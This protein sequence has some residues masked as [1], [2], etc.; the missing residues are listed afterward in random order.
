MKSTKPNFFIIGAP[1]CGT[2]SWAR[3][4]SDHQQVYMPRWKEPHFFNTDE[5]WV[6][7]STLKHYER[8]FQ[9]ATKVHEAIGEASVWYLYS[10]AAVPNI[11]LYS[12][13]AKY[14]VCLRSPI[15]MAYSLHGQSVFAGTENL[16]E[17]EV[18][19]R[20]SDARRQ[21]RSVTRRCR[22]PKHLVYKDVCKLGDQLERLMS[23]ADSSRVLPVL[24]DDVKK[25]P[26]AEYQRVLKFLGAEDD[27]RVVFPV[28]NSAKERRSSIL[29]RAV[30]VLGAAKRSLG[31]NRGLG[32]L[33]RIDGRNHRARPRTPMSEEMRRELENHFETDIIKLGKLL[34]RDLTHWLGS[35]V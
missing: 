5:N 3:W 20:D 10:R 16:F 23:I 14:I 25:N 31:I 1:K 34:D 22:E 26:P 17:F 29:R 33:N 21:G 35:K 28:T 15:E 19:W 8:L 11:E 12:P 4:L 7:T 30:M 2:T 27:G 9:G 6:H 32:L 18:A 24:L 13:G